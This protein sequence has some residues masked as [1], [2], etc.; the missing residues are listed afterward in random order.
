MTTLEL[1]PAAPRLSALGIMHAIIEG[2]EVGEFSPG[3]RLIE[4]ELSARFGAGRQL[5]RDALQQLQARGVV[6]IAPNRGATILRLT[7][8]QAGDTLSVTEM[9]FGLVAETAAARIAEGTSASRVAAA[10][11]GLEALESPP[12][13]RAFV[14]ARRRFF[15]ALSATAGNDELSHLL[16]QVRVHV[17]RAQYGFLRL[18]AQHT[19][20]L[21]AVGKAILS[22]DRAAAGELSRAHVRGLKETLMKDTRGE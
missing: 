20:E 10:I 16:R 11:A 3:Q 6:V 7:A 13:P 21:V 8:Q 19:D 17:L 5:V 2:L 15:S 9:L 22:A 4:A 14:T 18:R 1:P 12:S